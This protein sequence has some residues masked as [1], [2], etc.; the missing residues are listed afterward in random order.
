MNPNQ[1]E[2]IEKRIAHS[3]IPS[4]IGRGYQITKLHGDAS[5]RSY[6]RLHLGE[7]TYMLMVLP[8]DKPT[9]MAEEITKMKQI[10]TKLPFLEM[11]EHLSK[12]G[13]KVP[14][15][16]TTDLSHCMLLLEDF[17]DD[18]LLSVIQQDN[19]KIKTLYRSALDELK[20]I[21]TIGPQD[22]KDSVAFS[23]E[24]DAELY[25]L[26][27]IH[28]VEYGLDHQISDFKGSDREKSSVNLKKSQT[29][30]YRGQK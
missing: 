5:A 4:K 26:E 13:V 1:L 9:S 24:F 20:K 25:M 18:L 8:A 6:Y 22:P 27:F 29:H 12:K 23:R 15:V 28:F 21:S 17:G 3:S 11:Q 14:Q 10:R 2:S 7:K 19:S 16:I 30:T